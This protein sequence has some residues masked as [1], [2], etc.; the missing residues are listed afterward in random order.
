[1]LRSYHSYVP[2]KYALYTHPSMYSVKLSRQRHNITHTFVMKKHWMCTRW[3]NKKNRQKKNQKQ[4]QQQPK[5]K[6]HTLFFRITSG[7]FSAFYAHIWVLKHSYENFHLSLDLRLY[8]WHLCMRITATC[9]FHLSFSILVDAMTK[10]TKM[11]LCFSF[12]SGF[13]YTELYASLNRI[14]LLSF[15]FLTLIR[16]LFGFA[17]TINNNH[18]LLLS[19]FLFFIKYKLLSIEPS[20]PIL[21]WKSNT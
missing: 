9:Y 6:S 5:K 7:Y 2:N 14:Y 16:Y 1:M 20:N 21:M 15:E 12:A 3:W 17:C 4:H 11:S 8:L 10:T 18:N 19:F 13:R